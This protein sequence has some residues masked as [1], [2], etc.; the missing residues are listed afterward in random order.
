MKD[1][2]FIC[3]ICG[4]VFVIPVLEPGE[5]EEKRITKIPSSVSKMRWIGRKKRLM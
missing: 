4:H 2:K 3:K 5:A 1:G